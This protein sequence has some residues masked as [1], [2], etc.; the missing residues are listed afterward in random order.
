MRG[1]VDLK[2]KRL[3]VLSTLRRFKEKHL[4]FDDGIVLHHAKRSVHTGPN[5]RAVVARHGHGD[6][7]DGNGSGL[8]CRKRDVSAGRLKSGGSCSLPLVR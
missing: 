4:L 3:F 7:P 5:H 8:R 2:A 6:Q 1:K